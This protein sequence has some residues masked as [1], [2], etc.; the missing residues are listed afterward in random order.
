MDDSPILWSSKTIRQNSILTELGEGVGDK[1]LSDH[2]PAYK[3]S[4]FSHF[5]GHRD[6]G[7]ESTQLYV[8]PVPLDDDGPKHTLYCNNRAT[9]LEAMSGGGRHGFE[10]PY[11]PAGC[12]YRWYS[13]PEICMILER[14]DAIV[15]IGDDSLKQI[16]AAFNTLLRENM[17]IGSLKQWEL[18]ESQR[19]TCS[20]DNQIT[21]SECSSHM[22]MESQ[23]VRE[24][25]D[26]DSHRSPFYCD[27][28]STII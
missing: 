3:P 9:L 15:F 13:T 27:R 5:Q 21:K 17:A 20:C 8:P 28:K 18:N 14:F 6:C 4:Y 24:K 23:T 2:S 19:D 11:F 12:H 1:P 22:I 7:I 25:D 26:K 10:K 16:Y